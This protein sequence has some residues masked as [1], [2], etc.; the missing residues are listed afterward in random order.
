M[1]NGYF[2]S[3]TLNQSKH[4]TA[5]PSRAAVHY[6]SGK[7]YLCKTF[8][9]DDTEKGIGKSWFFSASIYLFR[10]LPLNCYLYF[11]F[12]IMIVSMPILVFI[13]YEHAGETCKAKI[14]LLFFLMWKIK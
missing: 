3:L 8:S 13:L 12:I 9:V 10:L 4:R 2:I 7:M 5:A 11:S 14:M 1:A 6:V